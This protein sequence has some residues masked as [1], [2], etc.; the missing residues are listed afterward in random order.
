MYIANNNGLASK[1]FLFDINQIKFML[2]L[3]ALIS[4][5][6][7]TAPKRPYPMWLFTLNIVVSTI[8]I[9]KSCSGFV[10]PR[11]APNV[12]KTVAAANPPS[13][14]LKDKISM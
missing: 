11:T 14:R 4:I 7:S 9:K 8:A 2:N 3:K 10:L 6:P 1:T 5:P 12:I 13:S